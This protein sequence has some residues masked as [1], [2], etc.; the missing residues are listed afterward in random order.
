MDT[1]PATAAFKLM[2]ARRLSTSKAILPTER[3]GTLRITSA[4]PVRGATVRM[5]VVVV[6]GEI[7]GDV[8][9]VIRVAEVKGVDVRKEVVVVRREVV[10]DLVPGPGW[11]DDD[12][13]RR[14]R[15]RN[16]LENILDNERGLHV[17]KE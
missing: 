10:V 5:G 4:G 17:L 7:V 13:R 15:K 2:S 14:A 3:L 1:R 11:A 16:G 8:V 6:G 9:V 12:V